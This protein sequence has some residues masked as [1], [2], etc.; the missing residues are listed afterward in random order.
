[1][2]LVRICNFT[3]IG[4]WYMGSKRQTGGTSGWWSWSWDRGNTSSYG[5]GR[6]KLTCNF[7]NFQYCNIDIHNSKPNCETGRWLAMIDNMEL[8]GTDIAFA[9]VKE[10]ITAEA[11]N[12][13]KVYTL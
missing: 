7:G 6:Y 10:S 3:P 2:E 12:A 13:G 11:L 1:M 8:N 9:R 4:R 5:E